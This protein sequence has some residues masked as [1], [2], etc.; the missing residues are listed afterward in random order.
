MKGQQYKIKL[1]QIYTRLSG[2]PLIDNNFTTEQFL[3]DVGEIGY[4]L[5]ENMSPEQQYEAYFFERKDGLEPVSG[6]Y[7]AHFEIA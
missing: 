3:K 6:C 4:V 2:E 7:F 1:L 5:K